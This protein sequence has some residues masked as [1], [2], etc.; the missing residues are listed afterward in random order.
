VERRKVDASYETLEGSMYDRPQRDAGALGLVLLPS[1]SQ[2]RELKLVE[3]SATSRG[4]APKGPL[5][6]QV[7]RI[8]VPK[9]CQTAKRSF[10]FYLFA[11]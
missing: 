9:H 1:P 4:A 3:H 7:L 2:V 10:V 5:Q 11:C 6:G 8:R